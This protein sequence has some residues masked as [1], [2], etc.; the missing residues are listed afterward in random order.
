MINDIKL[1]SSSSLLVKYADD[2][3]VS[4]SVLAEDSN[5]AKRSQF[6]NEKG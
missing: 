3:T 4:I 5:I 1:V 2:I 6:Y